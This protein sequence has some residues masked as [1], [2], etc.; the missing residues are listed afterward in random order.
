MQLMYW[1]QPL[2]DRPAQAAAEEEQAD[3]GPDPAMEDYFYQQP[4]LLEKALAELKPRVP[5]HSNLFFLT[6][7]GY[8]GQD[9][10]M[11]EALT[12]QSQFDQR[13]GTEGHSLALVN[14][15]AT[16]EQLPIASATSLRLALKR[17]GQ[18]M[19]KEQD[20]LFLYLTSHGGADHKLAVEFGPMQFN[21]VDPQVLRQL[22]D[23]SGI[24]HRVVV[25]SACYSGGFIEPLKNDDTLVITAAAADK[26]SFGCSNEA[27][28]TYFGR[29]YFVDI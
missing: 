19:D 7:A 13:F 26:V 10:F 29:A 3:A 16:L 12:I 15:P 28:F 22:L 6:A 1:G 14:N 25:V 17:M 2:W 8:A 21:D 4:K 27:D 20:I 24:K 9:V 5:G 23:E 11:R 18:L